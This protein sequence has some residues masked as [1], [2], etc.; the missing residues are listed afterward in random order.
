MAA[1]IGASLMPGPARILANHVFGSGW[2]CRAGERPGLGLLSKPISHADAVDTNTPPFKPAYT[3]AWRAADGSP[4]P[5][6]SQM[7]AQV[8]SRTAAGPFIRAGRRC[9]R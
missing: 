3:M 1:E 9:P 8:S 6:A 7:T 4:S 2:H 5:L